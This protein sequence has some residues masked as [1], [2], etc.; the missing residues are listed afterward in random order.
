MTGRQIKYLQSD[1]GREYCNTEFDQYLVK[2]GIECRLTI[3]QQNGMAERFN[4]TLQDMARCL[5]LQSGL[6][7]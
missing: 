1:N 7:E 4:R 5:T 6:T 3:P 2:S